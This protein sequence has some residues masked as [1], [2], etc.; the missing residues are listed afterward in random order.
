MAANELQDQ[1]CFVTIFSKKFPHILEKIVFS[2]GYES[3]KVCMEVNSVWREQLAS[4]RYKSRVKLVFRKDILEDEKKLRTAADKGNTDEVRRLLSSGMV[5]LNCFKRNRTQ[6]NIAAGEGHMDIIQLLIENG[7]D[8]TKAD[9]WSWTPLHSAAWRGHIN[10]VRLLLESGADPKQVTYSG[11]TPLHYA[12]EHGSKEVA[13]LLMV[14]EHGAD[15]VAVGKRTETELAPFA[16]SAYPFLSCEI[17][18]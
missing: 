2:L 8:I 3:Y 7:A 1:H 15:P 17:V 5:D 16:P 9:Y 10:V 4:E 12:V 6:L 18:N 13:L 14:L 11:W